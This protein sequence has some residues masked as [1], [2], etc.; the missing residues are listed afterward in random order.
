MIEYA[1]SSACFRAIILQY[2]GDPAARER[3]ESCGNCAPHALDGYE[4]ELVRKILSGIARAGERYGRRRIASM[5]VGDTRGL[6]SALT[7]TSTR[8]LA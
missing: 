5:L 1:G 8:D 4:R 7:R 2:F 6:P 3:C